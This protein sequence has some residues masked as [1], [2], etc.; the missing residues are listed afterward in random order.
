MEKLI[1]LVIFVGFSVVSSIV[2]SA[3]EKREKEQALERRRAQA[4]RGGRPAAAKQKS[5]QSEIDSFLNEVG[6]GAAAS[7]EDEGSRRRKEQEEAKR[8]KQQAIRQR[9]KEAATRKRHEQQKK[10]RAAAAA[11]PR[12]QQPQPVQRPI[13]ETVTQSVESHLGKRS[14]EMPSTRGAVTRTGSSA[15]IFAMLQDR[16]GV[17]NAIVVNEILNRP[18]ALRDD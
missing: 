16:E 11:S 7:D 5:V 15:A 9:Q 8:R 3:K 17:R 18:R 2:K 10:Q 1:F 14:I 4:G 6:D 13:H 12:T